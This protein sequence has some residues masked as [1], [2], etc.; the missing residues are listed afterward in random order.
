MCDMDKINALLGLPGNEFRDDEYPD[1]PANIATEIPQTTTASGHTISRCGS[2][3]DID[4]SEVER[5]LSWCVDRVPLTLHT[6]EAV[7]THAAN[8]RSDS[9]QV[10]AWS[11][12]RFRPYR[13][14]NGSSCQT[15]FGTTSNSSPAMLA[16]WLAVPESFSSAGVIAL[17]LATVMKYHRSCCSAA[18]D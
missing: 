17:I 11:Q 5:Y 2:D 8:V 18:I 1:E 15:Q 16:S 9:R 12:Q 13:T 14:K 7:K 4:R 6:G 10:S 3:T